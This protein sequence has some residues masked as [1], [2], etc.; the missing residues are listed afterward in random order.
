MDFFGGNKMFAVIET[1][2]KQ[3]KVAKDTIID[4]EKIDV[5]KTG[6]VQFDKVL[7]VADKEKIE[8]GKPY[9]EGA[10][11][12]GTVLNQYKDKKIIVYKFKRK[13]GYRLKQGHR[14]QL[15]TIKI[16][17]IKLKT[18]KETKE[19]QDVSEVKKTKEPAKKTS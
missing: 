18:K 5:E 14:Q 6:K 15:T 2:S 8:I 16:E 17:S 1:G 3:Y 4:I 19:A 10:V 12:T 13:T 7:L 9:V 11:V